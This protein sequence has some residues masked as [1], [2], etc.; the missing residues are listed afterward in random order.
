MTRRA[1]LRRRAGAGRRALDGAYRAHGDRFIYDVRNPCALAEPSSHPRG[2]RPGERW[3]TRAVAGDQTERRR[4]GR[5]RHDSTRPIS[6]IT[7]SR[8]AALFAEAAAAGRHARSSC[9]PGC[10]SIATAASARRGARRSRRAG[11]PRRASSGARRRATRSACRRSPSSTTATRTI[12]RAASSRPSAP[13]PPTPASTL[14]AGA[15]SGSVT[16]VRPLGADVIDWV[17]ASAAERWHTTNIR[18]VGRAASRLAARRRLGRIGPG[19]AAIHLASR[20]G[21]G[22]RSA[23]QVRARLRAA[24]ARGLRPRPAGGR[25]RSGSRIE[26]KRRADGPRILGRRRPRGAAAGPGRGLRRRGQLLDTAYQEIR[27]VDMPGR[28]VKV[29]LRVR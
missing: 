16:R 7:T 10:A 12:R 22:A 11:G 3:H 18:D 27:G 9:I 29:G 13:G 8:A 4:R 24:L 5:P 25:S 21:R 19:V 1:P 28:W 20:R 23:V 6:A 17:R 15:W 14:F 2:Q 26:F